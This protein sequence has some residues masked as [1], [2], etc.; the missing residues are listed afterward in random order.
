MLPYNRWAMSASDDSSGSSHDAS[1]QVVDELMTEL[2]LA[3]DLATPLGAGSL[4]D[5]VERR[6]RSLKLG[7]TPEWGSEGSM[8][9]VAKKESGALDFYYRPHLFPGMESALR[10]GHGLQF[11]LLPRHLPKESPLR[12][13]A[14]LESYS[15]G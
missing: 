9:Q 6:I 10:L 8:T 4:G 13:A 15:G 1:E 14:V 12:I 7:G 11:D 5:A 3:F 2:R